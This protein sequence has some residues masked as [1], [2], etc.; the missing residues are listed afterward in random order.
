M[1]HV[2]W[3]KPPRPGTHTHSPTHSR[4]RSLSFL[5]NT[6]T[7]LLPQTRQH[8][9]TN[10]DAR[11]TRPPPHL[12][13]HT[14]RLTLRALPDPRRRPSPTTHAVAPLASTLPLNTAP[15]AP[16]WC[17]GRGWDANARPLVVLARLFRSETRLARPSPPC[18]PQNNDDKGWERKPDKLES[19]TGTAKAV[20]TPPLV[21]PHWLLA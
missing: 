11:T 1:W 20:D 8:M 13:P 21:R 14:L 4:S 3:L 5:L 16:P 6:P 12:P 9:N 2:A 19:F 17:G 18:K 15:P 7:L 10:V